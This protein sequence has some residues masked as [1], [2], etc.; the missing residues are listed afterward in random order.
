MPIYEYN[1]PKC[2]DFDRCEDHRWAAQKCPTCKAKVTKLISNPAFHL[3]GGGWYITDYG[4]DGRRAAHSSRSKSDDS[5]S[6]SSASTETKPEKKGAR[7]TEGLGLGRRPDRRRLPGPGRKPGHAIF[8]VFPPVRI[9]EARLL[10]PRSAPPA[11]LPVR[12]A[13]LAREFVHPLLDIDGAARRRP[14][15]PSRGAGCVRR[16]R[17][18]RAGPRRRTGRLRASS[19]CL[20]PPGRPKRTVRDSDGLER[21][22][23]VLPDRSRSSPSA[24]APGWAGPRAAVELVGG[25]V[26]RSSWPVCRACAPGNVRLQR[27]PQGRLGLVGFPPERS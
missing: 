2:G 4:R 7:P 8:P 5:S 1:C 26:S 27:R 20:G 15:C 6:S 16:S 17:R 19:S 24:S 11:G 18:L 9:G 13:L 10:P 12:L 21:R 22:L 14:F 23:D 3:K 25:S